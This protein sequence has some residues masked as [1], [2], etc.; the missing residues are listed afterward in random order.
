MIKLFIYCLHYIISYNI[1]GIVNGLSL[2]ITDAMGKTVYAKQLNKASDEQ[3]LLINNYAKGNYICTIF[4]N[5]KPI[6][7]G[8]FIQ[9]IY[10]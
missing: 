6:K 8:K 5:G 4:N 1:S 9:F 10:R 2:S 7:S 3:L